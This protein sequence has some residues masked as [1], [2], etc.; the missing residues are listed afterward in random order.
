MYPCLHISP[1][2][3]PL[4]TPRCTPPIPIVNWGV[5]GKIIA[6]LN[7]WETNVQFCW[8]GVFLCGLIVGTCSHAALW[9]P[10]GVHVGLEVVQKSGRGGYFTPRLNTCHSSMPGRRIHCFKRPV[11]TLIARH[12]L[13]K[14]KNAHI[15][16][17]GTDDTV[18]MYLVW[19]K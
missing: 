19:P 16:Y 18:R 2:T 14:H 7:A 4:Q 12:K 9:V 13:D 17:T 6:C 1:V 11:E 5:K 8:A 10:V 15:V 3:E